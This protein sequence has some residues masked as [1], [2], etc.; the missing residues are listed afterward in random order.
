MVFD[1]ADRCRELQHRDEVPGARIPWMTKRERMVMLFEA[2][3]G[4]I[5]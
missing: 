5:R 2:T 4:D 3:D 1:L